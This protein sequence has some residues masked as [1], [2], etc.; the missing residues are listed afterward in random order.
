[1]S[2]PVTVTV[3]ESPYSGFPDLGIG[4]WPDRLIDRSV[5]DDELAWL[6]PQ[7]VDILADIRTDDGLYRLGPALTLCRRRDIPVWLYVVTP[8]RQPERALTNLADCLS[9]AS[10]DVA[11]ML[12]TPAAYLA[13]YQPDGVWPTTISPAELRALGREM[14]PGMHFGGG[15]PTYFT[16]LNRCRPDPGTIDF[17]THATSPIVHA[18]DDLSVMESLESL[19]YVF[20]SARALAPHTPYRVTTS[21]IGAWTNP[22]GGT[23]TPNPDGERVT[24]SENDPRQRALFA[25]AWNVGYVARAAG[26]V[27]GL[28]LSSI[29]APFPVA[30]PDRRYPIADVL[31]GLNR[32]AGRPQLAAA[33]DLTPLTAV[34]WRISPAQ[35]ELW[36]ANTAP[37]PVPFRLDNARIEAMAVLD[38]SISVGATNDR[39]WPLDMLDTPPAESAMLKPFAV[40]RLRLSHIE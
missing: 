5:A 36:I 22:Y 8:D 17:L 25:A 14:W 28:T 35:G 37:K 18:A 24:L 2:N 13:S 16:E 32:G 19:P 34:G 3:R 21:A 4:L 29:G 7:H 6:R 1:M 9:S 11:G 23:L 38:E 31:R 20:A 27:D 12:L 39:D 26:R 33:P 40:A 15:F 10:A 30:E